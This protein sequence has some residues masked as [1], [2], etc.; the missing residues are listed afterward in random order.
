M[1][2]RK[3]NVKLKK[4]DK[5][6]LMSDG[7][8]ISDNLDEKITVDKK[9]ESILDKVIFKEI[10]KHVEEIVL[11]NDTHPIFILANPKNNIKDITRI[12][13]FSIS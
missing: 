2:E 8:S 6:I 1:K 10:P 4:N 7:I 5:N 11:M 9:E 3:Q 12:G 13:N